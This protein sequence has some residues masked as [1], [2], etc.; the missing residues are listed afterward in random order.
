MI[1][2]T[3]REVMNLMEDTSLDAR[4][5]LKNAAIS[6]RQ[7]GYS[8][9][10]IGEVLGI[11]K[12][13]AAS[14]ATQKSIKPTVSLCWMCKNAVPDGTLGCSWSRK[15]KPVEG[16]YAKTDKIG[17]LVIACPEFINDGSKIL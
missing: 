7:Q 4:E 2:K 5:T 9:G 14:H 11:S 15:L 16:W 17:T 3:I 10:A 6:L 1:Q 8:Y 13:T 12:T